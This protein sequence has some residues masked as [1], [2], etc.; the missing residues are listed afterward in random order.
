MRMINHIH[1]LNI[2]AQLNDL[3]REPEKKTKKVKKYRQQ[4]DFYDK[5]FKEM[6]EDRQA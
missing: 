3:I 5:K 4:L 6:K 1:D 2:Q